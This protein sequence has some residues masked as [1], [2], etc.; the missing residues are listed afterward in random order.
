MRSLF[1]P[2]LYKIKMLG[3]WVLSGKGDLCKA[4]PINF[5]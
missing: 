2:E 5:V 3:F 4:T 1:L